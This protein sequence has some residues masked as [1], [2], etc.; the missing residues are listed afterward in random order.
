MEQLACP[1][2]RC[3]NLTAKYGNARFGNK[4]FIYKQNKPCI[5]HY[6]TA[7]IIT[8]LFSVNLNYLTQCQ[9]MVLPVLSKLL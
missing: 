5:S 9:S 3:Y 7:D 1:I 6:D 8:F 4:P 2:K